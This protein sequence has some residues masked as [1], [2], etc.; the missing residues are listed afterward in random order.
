MYKILG[1]DQKEYGPVTAEQL[2]QWIIEGRAN[3]QSKIKVENAADWQLLGSLPEFDAD[4]S[5]KPGA[6]PPPITTGSVETKTSGMAI[7]SLVLG[8]L[9]FCGITALVGLILGIIALTKINRSQ[10]R[11]TG[12]GI[13]IAG[14]CVSGFMLLFSIPFMAGL[15][16][17][18]LAKAKQKAQTINCANN[19]KQLALAVRIYAGDN[20][21][22][23]PPAATWCDAIQSTVGSAK[24]F[25]CP[26]HPERRSAYAFN[27]NLDG[28]KEGEINPRTVLLFESDGGWNGTGGSEQ[29]VA[30]QHST[31]T[32]NV[33]FADGSVAQWP[34]SQLSSQRWE[35]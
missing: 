1:T 2:R 20:T 8:V 28:K 33:A 15:T 31:R 11:L 34:R 14:I 6:T 19:M 27:R 12:N 29:L 18:A 9:G 22:Q 7:A 25:Q 23:Y 13:A 35:P 21:D 5:A 10:G 4:L 26:S 17:P 3:A 16:L 24:V 30:H 32:V